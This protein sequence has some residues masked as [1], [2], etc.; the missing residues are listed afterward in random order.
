[1]EITFEFLKKTMSILLTGIILFTFIIM[2]FTTNNKSP[3]YI[4]YTDLSKF[5]LNLYTIVLLVLIFTHTIYPK[6]ICSTIAKSI[7]IILSEKGKLILLAFIF[8]M[9]FGTG[10]KPQK[11]FG[12]IG[13]LC[14]F[15]LFI[16]YLCL[17]CKN[18]K[19]NFFAEEKKININELNK[20]PVEKINTENFSNTANNLN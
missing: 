11:I 13:C 17:N 10:S 8:I 15:G 7:P 16:C 20:F 9:Y 6:I 18:I 4:E 19:K 5:F 3:N 12:L 1:M 14:T 2:I